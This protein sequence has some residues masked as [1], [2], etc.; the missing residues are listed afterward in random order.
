MR[1]DLHGQLMC[2]FIQRAPSH[3]HRIS[4]FAILNGGMSAA[5]RQSRL[6]RHLR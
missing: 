3:W 6:D 2:S 1:P 5:W 4:R